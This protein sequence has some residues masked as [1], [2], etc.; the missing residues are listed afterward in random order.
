MNLLLA[1]KYLKTVLKNLILPPSQAAAAGVRRSVA[2]AA[3]RAPRAVFDSAG[4][5]IVVA[6]IDARSS[7]TGSPL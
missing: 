1:L 3:L 6:A 5:G 4:H 7:L 2:A